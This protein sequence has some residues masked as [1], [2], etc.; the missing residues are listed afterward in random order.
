DLFRPVFF[1]GQHDLR[2][3]VRETESSY[4]LDVEMPGYKKE[5]IKVSL[6][7]GYLTVSAVKEQKEDKTSHFIRKEITQTCRRSFYVGDSVT[8]EQI[9]AKYDN[10]VLSLTVPKSKPG[11]VQGKFISIE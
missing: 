10:G 3:D 8:E 11:Q 1:D 6:E 7:Q 5:Q 9:K 2:T 4:E